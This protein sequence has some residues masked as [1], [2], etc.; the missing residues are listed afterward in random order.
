MATSSLAA[1]VTTIPARTGATVSASRLRVYGLLGF[2]ILYIALS[3]IFT[4]WAGVPGTVSAFYRLAIATLVLAPPMAH[5]LR[6]GRVTRDRRVWLL[7]G[8]AGIFFALD[9]ALWNTSLFLTSAATSTLLG[10]DAP[11]VVGLGALL[12][13]HERLRPIYWLGLALA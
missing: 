2:G 6:R 10:N 1:G 4:R 5:G 13:F 11:I 12:I 3:A 7:A 8:A 9:L